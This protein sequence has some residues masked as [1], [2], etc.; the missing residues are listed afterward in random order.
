MG[1]AMTDDTCPCADCAETCDFCDRPKAV[2]DDYQEVYCAQCWLAHIEREQQR[3]N[4]RWMAG[5]SQ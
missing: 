3:A 1:S 5:G 2:V 4:D